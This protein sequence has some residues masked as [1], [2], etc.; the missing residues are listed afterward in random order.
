M[1]SG[2]TW[3]GFRCG[4]NCFILEDNTIQP[5]VD[6]GND[7]VMWSGNHVGHHSKIKD[8]VTL[9]GH[10]VISGCCTIE[11]YSFLAPRS[12]VRDETVVADYPEDGA[13]EQVP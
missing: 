2:T 8:H 1:T 9:S 3:P 5:Y 6:I 13:A 12:T 4:D 10:V 7:V 11:E